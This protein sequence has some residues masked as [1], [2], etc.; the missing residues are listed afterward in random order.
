MRDDAS[1]GEFYELF[2]SVCC[3]ISFRLGAATSPSFSFATAGGGGFT[4]RISRRLRSSCGMGL[5]GTEAKS[6]S[7]TPASCRFRR[8][9]RSR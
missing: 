2:D 8:R 3:S 5:L 4:Q 1:G 7:P 6:P 9:Q